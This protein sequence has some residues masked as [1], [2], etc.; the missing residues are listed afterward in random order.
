MIDCLKKL[1]R[2]N[3]MKKVE[4][5]KEVK[6]EIPVPKISII[7]EEKIET[8]IVP[9][10]KPITEEVIQVTHSEPKMLCKRCGGEMIL[11]KEVYN[12]TTFKCA[13]CNGQMS[14]VRD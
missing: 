13:K 12:E 10:K 9:I 3:K 11:L 4:K 2:C 14:I 8:I 6:K 5:K 1:L 7:E